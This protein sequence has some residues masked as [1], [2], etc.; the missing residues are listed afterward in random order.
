[1]S[2]KGNEQ[3]KEDDAQLIKTLIIG[4]QPDCFLGENNINPL[5]S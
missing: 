3:Q 4:K 5:N 2:V 1:L